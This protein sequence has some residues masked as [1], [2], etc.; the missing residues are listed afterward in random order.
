[1]AIRSSNSVGLMKSHVVRHRLLLLV[2][3]VL[4]L[5]VADN[6]IKIVDSESNSIINS[7]PGFPGNLPF[8]L[9]TGYVGVG[10]EEEIQLFYYFIESERSP[11][12]DPLVL[13]LTGGPGC[14]A[15][16]GLVY[17]IGPLLFDYE[18][19][20]RNST[21]LQFNPYSWTKV[22]NIIFL[23]APVGTGFSYAMSWE[24][25]QNNDILAATTNYNFLRKWLM[26]HPKFLKNPLYI[27]GDSYSGLIV[28]IVA[29]EIDKGNDEVGV[30]PKMN[31]KGYVIG[32]PRTNAHDDSNSKVEFSYRKALIS[33]QLYE[34]AKTNCNGEYVDVDE[35]NTLCKKDLQVH[36]EC[37]ANLSI[38]HILEPRCDV[39]QSPKPR[40]LHAWALITEDYFLDDDLLLS[41]SDQPSSSMCRDYHY[42]YSKVWANNQTVQNAL[43]IREGSI[44][45]WVRCNYSVALNYKFNVSSSIPYH[46]NLINKGYRVLIYSGDQDS[47]VPYVATQKWI[48][49]L[50]LTVAHAWAPW[51]VNEQVA[52]YTVHYSD[53]KYELTYATIKARNLIT[54]H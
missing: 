31:L 30:E 22:S 40:G 1:M 20:N 37:T 42:I 18:Q 11:E 21:T 12:E 47:M 9:E 45:E 3:V 49:A 17:E 27:A 15:F 4:V 41:A 7:L 50:N 38:A 52:G 10:E 29:Q 13:W 44:K 43:Q 33:D 6:Y 51:F 25:Y 34:S 26:T 35:E 19:S 54:M 2:V 16:S 53:K 5:G 28:P 24:A 46:Q 32:N 8:K 23:D 39:V 48:A 14:S 36:S